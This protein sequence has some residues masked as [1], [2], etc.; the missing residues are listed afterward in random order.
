MKLRSHGLYKAIWGICTLQD[1]GSFLPSLGAAGKSPTAIFW[2]VGQSEEKL[3]M[4]G[5]ENQSWIFRFVKAISTLTGLQQSCRCEL[6]LMSLEYYE[7]QQVFWLLD[8][9]R[10]RALLLCNSLRNIIKIN[11]LVSYGLHW[12]SWTVDQL[13]N[14]IFWYSRLRQRRLISL[15]E[16]IAISRL[17]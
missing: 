3:R 10:V 12:F 11:A 15:F 5:V 17:L 1:Q 4:M 9:R 6:L 14:A 7:V 16:Y 2:H 8:T 13:N